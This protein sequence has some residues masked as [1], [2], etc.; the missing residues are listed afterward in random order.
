[1][2]RDWDMCMTGAHTPTIKRD[3]GAERQLEAPT[4]KNHLSLGQRNK[5]RA[6]DAEYAA[7]VKHAQVALP[8]YLAEV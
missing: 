4:G 7:G 3:S 2:Y 6:A 5:N 8:F 1:M